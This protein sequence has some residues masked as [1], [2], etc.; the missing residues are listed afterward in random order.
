MLHGGVIKEHSCKSAGAPAVT[1]HIARR[2]AVVKLRFKSISHKTAADTVAIHLD[3][4]MAIFKMRITC[5]T[6]KTAGVLGG[7][8][9]AGHGTVFD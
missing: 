9:R 8:D 3:I 5:V 2:G 1:G 6:H 7:V 4:G